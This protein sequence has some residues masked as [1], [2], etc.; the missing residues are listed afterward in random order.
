MWNILISLAK[1]EIQFSTT[2]PIWSELLIDNEC[3]VSYVTPIISLVSFSLFPSWTKLNLVLFRIESISSM[4]IPKLIFFFAFSFF[5]SSVILSISFIFLTGI[6]SIAKL[7]PF[8][9]K[10]AKYFPILSIV[11]IFSLS[12]IELNS[13]KLIWGW[14][15]Y[16]VI[17]SG[18]KISCIIVPNT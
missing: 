9:A 6:F 5:C 2:L 8:K 1:C 16:S 13:Y 3:P 15:V 17:P 4:V 14:I 10:Y 11:D 18:T 12:L 7:A